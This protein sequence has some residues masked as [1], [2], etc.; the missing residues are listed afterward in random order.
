MR[1]LYYRTTI[2]LLNVIAN[3]AASVTRQQN[4]LPAY[5]DMSLGVVYKQIQMLFFFSCF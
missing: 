1:Y 4:F 5:F 3:Q 2:L